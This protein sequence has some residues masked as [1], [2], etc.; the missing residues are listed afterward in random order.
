MCLCDEDEDKVH[1]GKEPVPMEVCEATDPQEMIMRLRHTC[2]VCV[3]VWI[4]WWEH[5]IRTLVCLSRRIIIEPFT[6]RKYFYYVSNEKMMFYYWEHNE[7]LK[8]VRHISL[9]NNYSLL[10]WVT[11]FT[12]MW[13]MRVHLNH[14]RIP[15]RPFNHHR[16]NVM[17]S[18]QL[19]DTFS[20]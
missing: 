3:Q 12:L 16:H 2:K 18:A 20:S 17:I 9:H 7:Y 6:R 14:S 10:N 19:C 5:R 13:W 8:Q 11:L 1:K 15:K 4:L